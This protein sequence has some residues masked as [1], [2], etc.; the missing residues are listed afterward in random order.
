M[1]NPESRNNRLD[2]SYRG[3][4]ITFFMDFK[5]TLLDFKKKIDKEIVLY[6]DKAIAE[7]KKQDTVIVDALRYVK[8][9]T[10]AGGKRIRSA[11]MYYGYLGAGGKEKE[12]MLKASVSI[13]LV[14]MFLLIHDD[15]IDRDIER[16]GME[17]VNRRYEKIGA[18]Y[19]PGKDPKHFGNSMA[20][21]IGDMIAALGNQIIFSSGFNEKSI[22]MALSRL[23]SIISCTGIGEAKD[24][25]IEHRGEATEKDILEMYEYKTAKYTIEGPL[26]L[27]TI[28]GGMDEKYLSAIS[29]YAIPVGIAFQIQDD[30]L[31][32]FGDEEKLGKE[33]GSDIEEGKITL[34]VVKAREKAN[35][36]QR[37]ILDGILGKKNLS[38]KDIEKF[39][40]VISETGALG[41]ANAIANRYIKKGKKELETLKIEKEAKDF[42]L[43]MAEYMVHRDV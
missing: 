2:F 11:L 16:H 26:H 4:G 40:S 35:R 32:I 36:E 8:K 33:V 10:L 23:Q 13:E 19:F 29:R 43:G 34:L 3:N 9:F 17:T 14:H 37:S 24:F 21:I 31:G 22:M 30:I 1:R 41:Y 12:K 5:E 6:L 15:V 27:G 20:I 39:R 38:E 42:L 25:Y 18:R 28:L 7:S